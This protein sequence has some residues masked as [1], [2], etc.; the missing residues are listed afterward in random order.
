MR[1]GL[2]TGARRVHRVAAG[3]RGAIRYTSPLP[4]AV[5]SNPDPNPNPTPTPNQVLHTSPLPRAVSSNL[6][7]NPN[8]TPNPDQ[9]LHTSP[10]P[11]AVSSSSLPTS[12]TP[13]HVSSP[14]LVRVGVGVRVGPHRHCAVLHARRPAR[15]R[16]HLGC[17]GLRA[18]VLRVAGVAQRGAEHTS[19]GEP[20]PLCSRSGASVAS[21]A[22]P[23]SP[24]SPPSP[25]PPPPP[26]PPAPPPPPPPVARPIGAGVSH[27]CALS[28]LD[29][30]TA[31]APPLAAA[32]AV[33]AAADHA[34]RF[35]MKSG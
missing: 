32:A 28:R 6:D 2:Q 21:R 17:M 1:R 27:S 14:T 33:D 16:A 12:A 31:S 11:R 10:L 20:I 4:R 18:G 23:P 35:V 29:T 9:V 13:W 26:P 30:C 7:P 22:P 3:M 15:P 8:P 19:I 24:P 25:P 5:S 34:R